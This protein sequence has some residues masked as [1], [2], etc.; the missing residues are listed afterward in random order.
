[1]SPS[2]P[3]SFPFLPGLL[4]GIVQSAVPELT[5]M[6]TIGIDTGRQTLVQAFIV[7]LNDVVEGF[8]AVEAFYE[9]SLH[10]E[11]LLEQYVDETNARSH[12]QLQFV[13]P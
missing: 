7:P 2:M 9:Y 6:P 4:P 1:M 12:N 5:T 11:M 8:Q 10:I 3:R 13:Y